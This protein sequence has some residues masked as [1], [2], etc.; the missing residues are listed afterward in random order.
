MTVNEVRMGK[1]MPP[2]EG[3]DVIFDPS[4]PQT[5]PKPE[6]ATA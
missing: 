2:V 3:G 1:V 5:Q 6:G 4:K